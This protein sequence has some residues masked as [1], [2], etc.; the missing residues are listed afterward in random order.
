MSYF[1]PCQVYVVLN[2][3]YNLSIVGR[4]DLAKSNK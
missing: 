4:L 3:V 1:I 2:K